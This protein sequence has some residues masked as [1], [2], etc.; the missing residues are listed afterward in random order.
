M[1]AFHGVGGIPRFIEYGQG[2][3]LWDVDG[4]RY[5]DYVLSWG[6][7]IL[8]HA[9]PQVV[10]ALKAAAERGTSYGAPT[11]I[12]SE[13]ASLLIQTFPSLEMLR[14][15]NSGTEATMSVLRLARAATGRSKI[16]K[17]AGC[18]HGHVDQLL[19]QAGSGVATLNL[20]DSP[21][22]PVSSTADTLIAPY[23]NL[24]A[25]RR[26]F[27]QFPEQIACV[28]VE[29][30]AGNMGFIVPEP[31]F[32][33]GL[34]ELCHQYGAIFILD[35]VMTG[36][37]VAPGGAQELWKLDPDLTC[38]GKVIGGGLPVGAYAGKRRF[39]E[40]VAPAGPVYQAG[41]LSGNPLAMA[42]GL[43]TVQALLQPGVFASI[44]QLTGEL[45]QG[46]REAAETARI[47]LQVACVGTMFGLYFL[48]EGG[49]R[50][51]DYASA[52]AFADVA[53]YRRFFQAMLM[54]GIYLAP[55]QFEAV[56]LSHAHR[57]DD[58]QA[59]CKA[60][61]ASFTRMFA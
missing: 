10:K 4:N 11:A 41:T 40:L 5:L 43:A 25:V 31:D 20:P 17:F 58:I 47:P 22:V 24:Q 56:F 21:G 32:L 45:V 29:P 6:P 28:I 7:M 23:N 48:T 9:H 60:I 61:Q 37:R 30:V 15:V 53:R 52:R 26:L 39:M 42:A 1:R 36:L 35:E 12:E 34:Q 49:V 19:I 8:G 57:K 54:Q 14:F 51:T 46:I 27:E 2:A 44:A 50:I 18:Y 55:G 3:Y 59:T 13:L 38:L 33:P 16:C